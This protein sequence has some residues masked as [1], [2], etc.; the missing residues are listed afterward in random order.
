MNLFSR[1]WKK[2]VEA[3][4]RRR[5]DVRPTFEG[6]QRHVDITAISGTFIWLLMFNNIE[7]HINSIKQLH[8]SSRH[9][10]LFITLIK[11]VLRTRE[12]QQWFMLHF[13]ALLFYYSL[14][15]TEC[16][17]LPR[18]VW[19]KGH[20]KWICRAAAPAVF[21]GGSAPPV[22]RTDG[23]ALASRGTFVDASRKAAL[24]LSGHQKHLILRILAGKDVS[25]VVHLPPD[26]H[27]DHWGRGTEGNLIQRR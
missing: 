3:A 18:P 21:R 16:E 5:R 26:G 14:K 27:M 22:G 1:N 7:H 25:H 8:I 6:T 9:L 11:N 10:F 20:V 2:R 17:A 23:P 13:M 12:V 19:I 24:H 15:V 4:A